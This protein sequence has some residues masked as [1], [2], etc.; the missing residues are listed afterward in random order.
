M[1][2]IA[3]GVIRV[4]RPTI[5]AHL[6]YSYDAFEIHFTFASIPFAYCIAAGETLASAYLDPWIHNKT[7]ENNW[8]GEE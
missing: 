2:R 1:P 4:H 5:I 8:P 3:Y 6:Y 7:K